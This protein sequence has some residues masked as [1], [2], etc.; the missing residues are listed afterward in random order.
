MT[1][2]ILLP[3]MALTMSDGNCASD[4]T[5]ENEVVVYPNPLVTYPDPN[6]RKVCSGDDWT[7]L[8]SPSSLTW[9]TNPGAPEALLML[10]ASLVCAMVGHRCVY[11]R[12]R[13]G[14]L[15]PVGILGL[16][17]HDVHTAS[18]LEL[19]V[20]ENPVVT[21][22]S[23]LVANRI[24][25]CVPTK[26]SLWVG[27]TRGHRKRTYTYSWQNV[28][29]PDVFLIEPI[30]SGLSANISVV[31]SDDIPAEG[32]YTFSILDTKDARAT[33]LGPSP[34]TNSQRLAT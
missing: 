17:R 22:L 12:C 16:W 23:I 29:D 11:R 10:G 13:A 31:P 28:D 24:Q 4:Q 8:G 20:L 18:T 33:P 1:F 6:D 15:H 25:R 2:P 32:T 7:A 30:A 19:S 3:S 27:G 5:W 9:E 26:P 21:T 14:D 34:F